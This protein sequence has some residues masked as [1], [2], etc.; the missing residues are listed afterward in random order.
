MTVD[1]INKIGYD[2]F[3]DE[4]KTIAVLQAKLIIYR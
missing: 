3:K 1:D 4:E 2:K